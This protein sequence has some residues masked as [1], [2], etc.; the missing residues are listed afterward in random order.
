MNRRAWFLRLSGPVTGVGN[1]PYGEK[2]HRRVQKT[3][4][5][6]S[7]ITPAP[8]P[9][10]QAGG[11]IV[12]ATMSL[13]PPPTGLNR[14]SPDRAFRV[15]SA[16]SG[17]EAGGLRS[18]FYR[19]AT[20]VFSAA[21]TPCPSCGQRNPADSRFC[22]GCGGTLHL[23]PHL[24]SCPRCGVVGKASATVCFWCHGP[25]PGRRAD[26]RPTM[27]ARASRFLL[28]HPSRVVVGTAV[29]AAVVV[30]YATYGQHPPV[31]ALQPA[32]ARSETSA[33]AAPVA[34][35]QA[36]EALEVRTAPVA[37]PQ[38]INTGRAGERKPPR[39]E[40]CTEGVAAL[41]LCATKAEAAAP[42]N[43][44]LQTTDVGQEGAK[45]PAD[46]RTCTNA[47]AALGLC[48]LKP[49]QRRD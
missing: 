20:R 47:L 45:E 31:D 1:E 10:V 4:G 49:A 14:P 38:A 15:G 42:G 16:L 17:R 8:I 25:L 34:S 40:A 9:R 35:P 7:V 26:V 32:A 13:K 27:V 39:P 36:V 23:P 24:A 6:A 33:P 21:T 46:P 44:N 28:R 18:G 11:C 12:V 41:G 48:T 43:K 5:D 19:F 37:R 22:G 30:G 2:N 3:Q 29:L